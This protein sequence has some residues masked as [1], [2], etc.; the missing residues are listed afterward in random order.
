[1]EIRFNVTG[2]DRKALVTAVS[3]I[4]GWEAVYKKA[5]TFA[6]VVNNYTIDKNGTL[7]SDDRTDAGEIHRLWSKLAERGFLSEDIIPD[8]DVDPADAPNPADEAITDRLSVEMPLEGFTELALTNL[9]KLV[10]SKAGLIRKSL[11]ADELPILRSGDRL[12]MPWFRHDASEAEVRAYTAFAEA[13]CRTAKTQTRIV[14]TEKTVPNEKY[15]MRCFLLRLGFIGDAFAEARKI[16]L[17]P[18]SGNASFKNG[19][20]GKGA[21]EPAQT[22]DSGVFE[23][24]AGVS[25]GDADSAANPL[26]GGIGCLSKG[27]SYDE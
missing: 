19:V 15:A 12:T 17:S 23:S 21:T 18:L 8:E 24:D 6:Y 3:E 16:L 1:M 11:G 14:A 20:C 22:A 7:I 10:A 9:S 25:R 4:V 5:P 2:A 27:G 13:L 26:T